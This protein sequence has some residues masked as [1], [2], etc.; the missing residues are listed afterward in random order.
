MASAAFANPLVNPISNVNSDENTLLTIPISTTPADNVPGSNVSFEICYY[1]T[2]QICNLAGMSAGRAE[3]G[4]IGGSQ[5]TIA[6]IQRSSRTSVQFRWTPSTAQ[7]GSSYKFKIRA[8]D[9]NSTHSR[10]FTV[11]VRDVPSRL[12]I[13]DSILVGG[14]NQKRSNPAHEDDEDREVWK[15]V[16]ITIN[17]QGGETLTDLTA[18]SISIGTE[19]SHASASGLTLADIGA[20]TTA[21]ITFDRQTIS[22]GQTATATAK[23]RIPEGL[24]AVDSDGKE[25][26]WHLATINFSARR[27][28]ASTVTASTRVNMQAE[29]L[30]T[31]TRARMNIS[32]GTTRDSETID[33]GDTI[34]QLKPGDSIDLRVEIESGFDSNPDENVDIDDI[35]VTVE[36][37]ALDI[38]DD[39]NTGKLDPEDTDS[40]RVSFDIPD[41]A[42]RGDE[43]IFIELIGEDDFGAVH[44]EFWEITFEIEREQHEIDIRQISLSPMTV[45]CQPS[46]E[47]TVDIRNIGRDDEDSVYVQVVTPGLLFEQRSD[48]IEMDEGDEKTRS[49]TIPIPDNT[50]AGNHKI[51]VETFYDGSERSHTDSTTLTKLEC[52]ASANIIAPTPQPAPAPK[53][54]EPKI[55]VQEVTPINPVTTAPQAPVQEQQNFFDSPTF[56]L[57]LIVGYIVVIGFGVTIIMTLAKK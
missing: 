4:R 50:P 10:D 29:N 35:T 1:E 31:I 12:I 11:N 32:S 14:S 33:D 55:I 49:F 41:D 30:L 19:A 20:T 22:P 6:S 28:G 46:T 15:N 21:N 54:D 44:G 57:L 56:L 34:E 39:D 38:D 16:A 7:G 26:K 52:G 24:S 27:S 47:L 48:E 43:D 8:Y 42:R 9:A 23:F 17:N 5:G 40:A 51:T 3:T 45:S 53:A 2:S 37:D 18:R 13:A 25:K 36:N